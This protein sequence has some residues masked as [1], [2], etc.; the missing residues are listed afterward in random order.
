LF[1]KTSIFV[2]T[3]TVTQQ[4]FHTFILKLIFWSTLNRIFNIKTWYYWY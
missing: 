1:Q 4:L 3:C 2:S